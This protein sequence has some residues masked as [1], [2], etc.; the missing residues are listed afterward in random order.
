MRYTSEIDNEN[1][2]QD[3]IFAAADA[4]RR[5]AVYAALYTAK[6]KA[7]AEAFKDQVA[8]AYIR[9]KVYLNYRERFMAVKVA[10]PSV[11]DRIGSAVAAVEDFCTKHGITAHRTA[12]AIVFRIK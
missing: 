12:G 1:V 4:R 6:Q 11:R 3:R 9:S 7:F 5:N 8:N 2:V 10:N